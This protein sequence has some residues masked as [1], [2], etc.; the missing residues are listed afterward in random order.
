MT[1]SHSLKFGTSIT[2]GKSDRLQDGFQNNAQIINFFG[3]PFAGSDHAPLQAVFNTYPF[4]QTEPWEKNYVWMIGTYVQDQWTLDRMTLNAGLRWDYF[5]GGYPDGGI[6]GSA[7][8]SGQELD[9]GRPGGVE[10]PVAPAGFVY[11]V[12]GDGRT[13]LKVTASRYVAGAGTTLVGTPSTPPS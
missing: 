10:R 2:R 5:R 3:S 12:R 4:L 6:P 8:G 9:G 13:A 11:D 7:L 1:G